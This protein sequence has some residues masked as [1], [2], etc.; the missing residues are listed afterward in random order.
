MPDLTPGH[1]LTESWPNPDT[2]TCLMLYI[3]LFSRD[4]KQL[5]ARLEKEARDWILEAKGGLLRRFRGVDESK[6]DFVTDVVD[7]YHRCVL[8][9]PGL[10]WPPAR[11]L[12]DVCLTLPLRCTTR[13]SFF[14]RN[15]RDPIADAA[16]ITTTT[17]PRPQPLMTSPPPL[18]QDVDIRRRTQP[19]P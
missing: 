11:S 10:T 17:T 16:L 6:R 7:V 9:W 2:H 14:R 8:A 18:V 19:L 5:F 4:P 15:R 1:F 13:A 3:R 12:T